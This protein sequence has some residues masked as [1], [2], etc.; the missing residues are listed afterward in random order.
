MSAFDPA[1]SGDP[2][3]A[4]KARLIMQL[5]GLAIRSP[6]VL[7]AL[8][9]VPREDFLPDAL[10]AHAYE[11]ASLPIAG[12]QT[13][14]QPYV[15]ARMTEALALNKTH[16][17]LEIG[18]GSGY[19]AAV[20][21]HL[22]RRVYSIERL[23]PLLVEAENLFRRLQLT[24]ITCRCG[25]GQKGWPEAAPYDRI[26]VTCRMSA[27]SDHLLGQLKPEGILVAPVGLSG[28]EQLVR[29]KK[30]EAGLEQE[31]LMDVRFVPMLDGVLD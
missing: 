1:V 19:Q 25:D 4:Q 10:K 6:Q 30:T 14:S 11:N 31:S 29:V 27:L 22:V 7:S 12:G 3:L 18:T 17:V 9:K 8:E 15:V 24:N 23:R 5:R 26:I 28:Q 20:L 21:S 16:R 13:I 2:Y